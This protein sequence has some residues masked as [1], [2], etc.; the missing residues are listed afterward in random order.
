[1]LGAADLSGDPGEMTSGQETALPDPFVATRPAE[2][3]A[4]VGKHYVYTCDTGW[5]CDT[6][7]KTERRLDYRV[8]GGIVE[9]RTR[10]RTSSG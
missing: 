4:F 10:K 9:S 5:Q 1:M 6:Y 2:M 7:I 8:H 3:A